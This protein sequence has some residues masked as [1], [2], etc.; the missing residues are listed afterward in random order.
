MNSSIISLVILIEKYFKNI[1]DGARTIR[2]FV[3]L[4]PSILSCAKL[5]KIGLIATK[6]K[7]L[8]S[9]TSYSLTYPMD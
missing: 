3:S 7:A 2:K 9:M 1:P 6:I 4:K 5:H 8:L